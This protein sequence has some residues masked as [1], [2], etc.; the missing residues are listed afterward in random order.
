MAGSYLY[1]CKRIHSK[2]KFT[3]LGNQSIYIKYIYVF[4]S[5]SF[6]DSMW[7]SPAQPKAS[8]CL[9]HQQ[10]KGRAGGIT[11][12]GQKAGREHNWSFHPQAVSKGHYCERF[13]FQNMHLFSSQGS[14]RHSN[15]A[16]P[17]LAIK[18]S[19]LLRRSAPV[20]LQK[21]HLHILQCFQKHS[22][23][24]LCWH[25][26]SHRGSQEMNKLHYLACALPLSLISYKNMALNM[27][28]EK[29]AGQRGEG[30]S[31]PAAGSG[32]RGEFARTPPS[33]SSMASSEDQVFVFSFFLYL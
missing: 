12:G 27:L 19:I 18:W 26:W 8:S 3:I 25:W 4:R 7:Q 16:A 13:L 21:L 17:G 28:S 9:T 33:P 32:W 10:S 31:C 23:D 24:G 5:S 22:K 29:K 14:I 6:S 15:I 2:R 11:A 30:C 20:G 1:K